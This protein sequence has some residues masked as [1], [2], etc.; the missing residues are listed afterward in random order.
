MEAVR[1][2]NPPA[3]TRKAARATQANS[4][5]SKLATCVRLAFACCPCPLSG[6]THCQTCSLQAA[7]FSRSKEAKHGHKIR[8]RVA[9]KGE[10]RG[11][12][13]SSRTVW[14][15]S[16]K[17]TRGVISISCK[18][19]GRS[20]AQACISPGNNGCSDQSSFS[21]SPFVLRLMG[22]QYQ[23]VVI[24][25]NFCTRDPSSVTGFRPKLA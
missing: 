9:G 7:R 25:S 21:E 20:Q 13:E 5:K 4:T 18:L 15:R 22:Q 10:R 23:I 19:A 16:A 24:P 3:N 6:A 1:C 2:V 14:R 17:C 12:S 8:G 11:E